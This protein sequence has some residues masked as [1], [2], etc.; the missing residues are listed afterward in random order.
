MLE[1]DGTA[2]A[3]N[4]LPLPSAQPLRLYNRGMDN[5]HYGFYTYFDRSIFLKQING[6]NRGGN[7]ADTDG[8][9]SK[10]AAKLR[11]TY[12][13]TRFLVQ[14]WTRSKES[15]P[16]LQKSASGSTDAF[17]RPGT[18][19]YPVTVTID[20]HGGDPA[21]KNLYCYEME[22]DGTIKNQESKKS[23]QFED[24]AFGGTLVKGTQGQ[25]SVSGSIDGGTGGCRCQ[26]QNWLN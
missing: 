22:D 20:R 4:L 17:K 11:C 8:G 10:D 19:P 2:A 13:Q 14:I 24:R 16:L 7:P 15:K 25:G 9:S 23:F 21:K 3:A 1:S 12:S 5:E 18:F 26:W 6:T